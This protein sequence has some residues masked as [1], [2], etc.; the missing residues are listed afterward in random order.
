M[1]P[2][3]HRLTSPADFR[4]T[5]RS[6]RKI[7]RPRAIVHFLPATTGA[8]DVAPA[9]VG[10]TVSKAVGG[11]VTRHRTAR[12]I[13]HA[14]A[15]DLSSLPQGSSWVVRAL[16]SAGKVDA[17]RQLAEDVRSAVREALGE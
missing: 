2:R 9:R 16:P 13:R 7:V 5:I 11:S 1:L 14:I 4:T 10:V 12:I 8:G 17:N 15:Q 6:G 3:L